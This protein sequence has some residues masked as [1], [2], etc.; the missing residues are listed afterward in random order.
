MIENGNKWDLHNIQ[1]SQFI[2]LLWVCRYVPFPHE[3]DYIKNGE[4]Q[5]QQ[6]LKKIF[7]LWISISVKKRILFHDFLAFV[8]AIENI[9]VER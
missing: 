8:Q 2:A 9:N 5:E 4:Q 3:E 6:E 1:Y 7:L